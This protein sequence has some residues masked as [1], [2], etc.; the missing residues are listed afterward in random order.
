[1]TLTEGAEILAT[2][3]GIAAVFVWII[4]YIETREER[5]Q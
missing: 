2:A 1:M 5:K 3:I 4:A